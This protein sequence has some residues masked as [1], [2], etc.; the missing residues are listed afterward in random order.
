V[1]LLPPAVDE[2]LGFVAL[3]LP[4]PD[5]P[6]VPMLDPDPLSG[7]VPGPDP[8][9]LLLPVAPLLPAAPPVDW[10]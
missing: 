1:L 5:M 3:S 10:A 9:V 4:V 2:Q 6:C 7:W 8:I